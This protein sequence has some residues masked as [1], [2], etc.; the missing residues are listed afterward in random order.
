MRALL[1]A[2]TVLASPFAAQAVEEPDHEVLVKDGRFEVRAYGPMITAAVEV[3]AD[4]GDAPGAGFRPLADYIFGDNTTEAD[5]DMTAPVTQT[6]TSAKIEMTAPVTQTQSG[7]PDRWTIA[8]V[9]PEEWTLDTLPRPLDPE[10][11]ITEQPTR[12]VA[13]IRFNGRARP[14]S[15][16]RREAELLEWIAARGYEI[17][18]QATYAYYD[19]PWT[20][21]PFRRNEVMIPIN[22]AD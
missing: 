1:A 9:M 4:Q 17:A 21:G 10:V 16:A 15:Q 7:D 22:S 18:G 6:A 8:F 13:V 11:S 3:E 19:P 12:R 2:T 14:A 5:I 20:L